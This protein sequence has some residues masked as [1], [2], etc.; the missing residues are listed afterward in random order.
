MAL[1]LWR[2]KRSSDGVEDQLVIEVDSE[3][4]QPGDRSVTAAWLSREALSTTATVARLSVPVR[5][6]ECSQPFRSTDLEW[7]DV[8][9][10]QEIAEC[11]SLLDGPH[12]LGHDECRHHGHEAPDQ[13]SSMQGPQQ[14]IVLGGSAQ[15]GC[16]VD[17]AAPRRAR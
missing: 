6:A 11:L 4:G 15:G 7:L 17:E 8:R 12:G 2:A 1:G 9:S 13:R 14:T 16:P 5:P 10:D 3:I